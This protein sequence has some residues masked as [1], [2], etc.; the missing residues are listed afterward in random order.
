M[1]NQSWPIGRSDSI[2]PLDEGLPL[3]SQNEQCSPS[4]RPLFSSEPAVQP[5][6]RRPVLFHTAKDVAKLSAGHLRESAT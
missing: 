3:L 1:R 2:K 5:L 4:A 6:E